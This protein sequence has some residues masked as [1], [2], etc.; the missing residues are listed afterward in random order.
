[1]KSIKQTLARKAVKSTARHSAHGAAAKLQRSPLRTATLLG[2]GAAA[3][4]LAAWKVCR[5]QAG[6]SDHHG[7]T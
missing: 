7:S 5:S 3:G 2:I 4:A 6:V 1:M